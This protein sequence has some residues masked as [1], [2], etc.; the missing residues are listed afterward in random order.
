MSYGILTN[1]EHINICIICV[2]K[3]IFSRKNIINFGN[4][5]ILLIRKNMKK[6]ML[7][8]LNPDLLLNMKTNM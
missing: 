6:T 7:L 4:Q 8:N 2:K 3:F 5:L 1:T